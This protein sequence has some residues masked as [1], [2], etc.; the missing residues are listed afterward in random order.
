MVVKKNI[1]SKK[2]KTKIKGGGGTNDPF[3]AAKIIKQAGIDVYN[4][5][6]IKA[7]VKDMFNLLYDILTGGK[8][9]EAE[10]TRRVLEQ[11]YNITGGDN[12]E[13]KQALCNNKDLL[14]EISIIYN[15]IYTTLKNGVFSYGTNVIAAV[16]IYGAAALLF[17]N[18]L[19]IGIDVK[20][21]VVNKF[22]KAV[23][24]VNDI[25]KTVSSKGTPPPPVT[26]GG[27]TRK[28]KVQKKIT[29]K[30]IKHAVKTYLQLFNLILYVKKNYKT[31]KTKKRK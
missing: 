15:N 10:F 5:V 11:L 26:K 13:I 25:K 8:K 20:K 29:T 30:Q 28:H 1:Y 14:N 3:K 27:G 19:K 9:T 31:N 22:M 24:I 4:E 12:C 16:P 23:T 18:G 17:I 7:I 6:N 21:D 2:L